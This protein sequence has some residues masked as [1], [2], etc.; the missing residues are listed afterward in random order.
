MINLF[1]PAF[2]KKVLNNPQ[3]YIT[4]ASNMIL[5]S[6]N[7]LFSYPSIYPT[8]P[9]GSS[10]P[11]DLRFKLY[12]YLFESYPL[13]SQVIQLSGQDLARKHYKYPLKYKFR[14]DHFV[15]LEYLVTRGY[16]ITRDF[17][18]ENN[19]ATIVSSLNNTLKLQPK[20]SFSYNRMTVFKILN[21]PQSLREA[22][23]ILQRYLEELTKL[24]FNTDVHISFSIQTIEASIEDNHDP[25]TIPHLDRFIP[26]LKAF[27]FPFAVNEYQSPFSFAPY[28]H[29]IDDDYQR[30]FK[31]A[32]IFNKNNRVNP[33]RPSNEFEDRFPL[34]NIC[35]PDNS[36]VL[37]FTNGLHR[38]LRFL[39]FP[40]RR[41]SFRFDWY[42]SL[43]K[44]NRFYV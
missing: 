7:N 41:I 23:A 15:D 4:V 29:I 42:S 9:I 17:L 24:F 16:C 13:Y 8:T 38:R 6:K 37:A 43:S 28:S 22:T 2:A 27:Y 31:D 33:F 32:Y 3:Q 40:E 25:N 11:F 26:T 5:H 20:A 12:N 18:P 21:I 30:C 14:P 35:V 10:I 36:L 39:S 1:T 19:Y 44:F 34:M